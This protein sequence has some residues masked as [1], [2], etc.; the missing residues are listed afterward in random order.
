ML[1]LPPQLMP[2]Q[3]ITRNIISIALLMLATPTPQI[4][5]VY[6]TKNKKGIEYLLVLPSWEQHK[7]S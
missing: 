6:N 7:L 5:G 1:M 4:H 3:V 2:R